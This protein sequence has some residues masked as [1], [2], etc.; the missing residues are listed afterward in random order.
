MAFIQLVICD[1]YLIFALNMDW[2]Y[3]L[4]PLDEAIL[5]SMHN[6]FLSQNKKTWLK[7]WIPQNPE[8]FAGG[9]GAATSLGGSRPK[10][11]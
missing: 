5:T 7:V 4:E 10:P 8:K 1:I 2:R 3:S 11:R 9:L 6:L